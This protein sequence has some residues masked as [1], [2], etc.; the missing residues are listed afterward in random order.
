MNRLED[1]ETDINK[2]T[3][4]THNI[5]MAMSLRDGIDIINNNNKNGEILSED[6]EIK[7]ISEVVTKKYKEKFEFIKKSLLNSLM[8]FFLQLMFFLDDYYLCKYNSYCFQI[9]VSVLP[10]ETNKVSGQTTW[11]VRSQCTYRTVSSYFF[12]VYKEELTSN[13]N[14]NETKTDIEMN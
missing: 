5:L 10:S 11:K 3:Y 1:D 9:C 12:T 13:E 14:E 8:K 4:V 6:D 2:I 7:L